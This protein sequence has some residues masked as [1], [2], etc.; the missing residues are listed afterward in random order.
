MVSLDSVR[1]EAFKNYTDLMGNDILSVL[2][3]KARVDG[4]AD[5]S[6]PKKYK[7]MSKQGKI[8]KFAAQILNKEESEKQI[9]VKKARPVS[10]FTAKGDTG[11]TASPGVNSP[12]KKSTGA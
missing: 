4:Q 5:P 6:V 9:S 7:G 1:K 12:R 2:I 10:I 8:E 3:K 11:S